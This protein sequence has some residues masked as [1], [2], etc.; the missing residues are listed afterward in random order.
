MKAFQN[1][2]VIYSLTSISFVTS[3]NDPSKRQT[4]H[5]PTECAVN[6]VFSLVKWSA[7][8]FVH[9]VNSIHN[10]DAKPCAHKPAD[11]GNKLSWYFV[12]R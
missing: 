5:K 10:G 6:D 7:S 12:L 9:C 8:F 4:P 3:I 2:H 11:Q 1:R